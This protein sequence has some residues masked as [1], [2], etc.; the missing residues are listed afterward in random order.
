M[1]DN[2]QKAKRTAGFT[3]IEVV[4]SAVIA[5]LIGLVITK[6]MLSTSEAFTL[7]CN[8]AIVKQQSEHTMEIMA[9]RIRRANALSIVLSNGNTTI[10]FLDT[11][12]ASNIQY[13]FVPPPAGGPVWGEIRQSINGAQASIGGYAQN[14]QFAVSPTGLVTID[15][16]FAKGTGRTQATLTVQ[17][18]AAARN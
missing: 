10:D 1:K 18:S 3:L 17:C 7:D 8:T 13:T 14:L 16:A 6:F 15:A 4:I 9:D 5:V 12:D 2:E 11:S